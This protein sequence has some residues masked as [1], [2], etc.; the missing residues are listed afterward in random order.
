MNSPDHCLVLMLPEATHI[1]VG[2]KFDK[3]TRF[4]HF[5]TLVVGQR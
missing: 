3:D 4:G 1:G 5:W 2:Y